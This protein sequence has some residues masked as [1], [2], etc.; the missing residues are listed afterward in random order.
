MAEPDLTPPL[1]ERLLMLARERDRLAAGADYAASTARS[2]R[3]DHGVF[4][5]FC[6]EIGHTCP[7]TPDTL[8]LYIAH[9]V[10]AGFKVSTIRRR[11]SA[12]SAWHRTAG[13][14]SPLTAEVRRLLRGARR[15]KIEGIRK[16]KPLTLEQVRAI[17]TALA[18][19]SRAL[20]VRDRAVI[21]TGITS[22]LRSAN[23]AALRLEDVEWCEQGVLLSI[24]RS[25]TDQD[26][27]RR[28]VIGIPHG[29]H[30]ET[31]AV[32]ALRGWIDRRSGASSGP[33]FSRVCGKQLVERPLQAEE[34][35]DIVRRAVRRIGLDPKSFGSNS[36]RAGFVTIARAHGVTDSRIMAQTLHVNVQTLKEYWR[37]A[38]VW[39]QNP[40][41]L[42]DL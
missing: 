35:R 2:Y 16:V 37:P 32:A 24:H 23:L 21:L 18:E 40:L 6:R 36:L 33:L 31:C 17:S 41:A 11:C 13:H 7:A 22:A 12:V 9:L 38:D 29:K 15:L 28:A 34:F 14:A 26:G 3:I 30:P 25:K 8:A 10:Q 19:D 5:R 27:R 1:A 42:M 20:A 39:E 4:E